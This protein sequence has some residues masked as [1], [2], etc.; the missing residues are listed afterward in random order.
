[1]I[2]HEE[3]CGILDAVERAYAGEATDKDTKDIGD[4][5]EGWSAAPTAEVIREIITGCLERVPESG[6]QRFRAAGKDFV[7]AVVRVM[8]VEA[9]ARGYEDAVQDVSIAAENLRKVGEILFR[10]TPG[11]RCAIC[12]AAQKKPDAK[13]MN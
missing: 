5:A 9:Y 7:S 6:W 2:D 10:P 1:M 8:M 13:E 11:C 12:S 4:F 3:I